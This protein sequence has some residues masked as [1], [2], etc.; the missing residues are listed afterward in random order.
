MLGMSKGHVQGLDYTFHKYDFRVHTYYLWVV[1]P[2]VS[3]NSSPVYNLL[4]KTIN[5]YTDAQ[6]YLSFVERLHVDI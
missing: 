6:T 1:D 5:K 4:D 2:M 3:A